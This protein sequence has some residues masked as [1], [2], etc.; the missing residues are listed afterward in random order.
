M[1]RHAWQCSNTMKDSCWNETRS[2]QDE[3]FQYVTSYER[4]CWELEQ[5]KNKFLFWPLRPR[6]FRIARGYLLYSLIFPYSLRIFK[7]FGMQ[8]TNTAVFSKIFIFQKWVLF[9]IWAAGENSGYGKNLFLLVFT[10]C[11]KKF[12]DRYLQWVHTWLLIVPTAIQIMPA[13][14]HSHCTCFC[15][16]HISQCTQHSCM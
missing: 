1:T 14:I 4:S 15:K 5:N 9:P 3:A 10:F 13:G 11:V 2:C 7:D 8:I 16:S 6:I 12:T